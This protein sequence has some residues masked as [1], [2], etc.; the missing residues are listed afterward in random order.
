[1]IFRLLFLL[2]FPAFLSANNLPGKIDFY[3]GSLNTAKEIA[4]A[5]G[6]LYFVQFTASWCEPCRWM[7]EVTYK[8]PTLVA[9]INKN[10][11]PVKV[12]IDD[13]DGF[14]YKQMYNIRMLPS[15]LVF[16]SNGELLKKYEE[17]LAPLK[18]LKIL[19]TH[20]IPEN[21]TIPQSY[22]HTASNP[23]NETNTTHS[24]IKENI[25]RPALKPATSKPTVV[26]PVASI[27]ENDEDVYLS[28]M[29]EE[30]VVDKVE[31]INREEDSNKIN[32]VSYNSE[33]F[34]V[35]VGVY[36]A[37]KNVEG[38]IAKVK[39]KFDDQIIVH[40]RKANGKMSYIVMVGK[41]SNAEQANTFRKQIEAKGFRGVVKNLSLLK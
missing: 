11:I 19:Q 5:E 13:F 14:A 34:S 7:D 35:Q 23:A 41:F 21:R 10:Y 25:T 6:K 8:D 28:D 31:E 33:G 9:Y 36:S 27:E 40:E 3:N 24:P 15:V 1:M 12:D 16:S 4:T 30:V 37:Y 2:A 39:N 17:S 20:N 26:K 29:K 22:N 38:K 18:M 32:K